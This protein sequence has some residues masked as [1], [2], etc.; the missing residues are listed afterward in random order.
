MCPAKYFFAS[1][2]V[3]FPCFILC[4]NVVTFFFSFILPLSLIF[5]LYS[6]I[7]YPQKLTPCL[8]LKICVFLFS[9][10]FKFSLKNFCISCNACFASCFVFTITMLSSRDIDS[11]IL[12]LVCVLYIYQHY[13]NTRWRTFV[14]CSSRISRP[15]GRGW[16]YSISSISHSNCGSCIFLFIIFSK[17]SLSMLSK[18]FAISIFSM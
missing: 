11:S 2:L 13:L 1:L 18:Y 5:S 10:S 7:L 4:F 8:L 6:F 12:F 15:L 9:S 17:I 16:A 3:I 14:T